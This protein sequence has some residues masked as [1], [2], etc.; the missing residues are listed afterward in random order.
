MPL[1]KYEVC[2][3]YTKTAGTV[4]VEADDVHEAAEKYVEQVYRYDDDI[5]ADGSI[6][7]LV[8][9][10]DGETFEFVV[11]VDYEPTY[12]AKMIHKEATDAR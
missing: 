2:D 10:P 7:V 4:T 8:T 11:H 9:R 1:R 5:R 3:K 12:H 6:R